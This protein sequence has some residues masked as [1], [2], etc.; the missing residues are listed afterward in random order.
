MNTVSR[1]GARAAWAL[2]VIALLPFFVSALCIWAPPG[3]GSSAAAWTLSLYAA[4]ILIFMGALRIYAGI[5]GLGRFR[6]TIVVLAVLR[7]LAT[8]VACIVTPIIGF[9]WAFAITIAAFGI[10]GAWDLNGEGLPDVL[11]RIRPIVSVGALIS[12]LI[13]FLGS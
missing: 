8:S 6:A 4:A 11:Q 7:P 13:G 10:Q 9:R 5:K 3:S 12:L 2:G 1:G